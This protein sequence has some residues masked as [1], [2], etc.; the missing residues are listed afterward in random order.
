MP[1][2]LKEVDVLIAGAGPAGS[3]C[4]H[5][6]QQAGH[7]CLVVDPAEFPR[8]KICGG[9][10]TPRGW[11][12]LERLYPGLDYDY[13]PV[14]WAHLYMDGRY[15][16]RYYM[17]KEIRVVRR[18]AFD[19]LLLDEYLKAGG[20]I[21]KDRVWEVREL[22]DGRIEVTL[23]SGETVRCRYLVGA[24]GAGSRVRQYLN[25]D[26]KSRMLIFEQYNQR[27]GTD[28]ISFEL[29]GKYKNG[30][31][32]LFPNQDCDIAGYC[33]KDATRE[34]FAGVLASFGIEKTK[35][36][37]AFITTELDYPFHP[38]ILLVGDAGCWCDS[39]SYE[40]IYFALATGE[41]AAKAILENRPFQE[42]NASIL[43][44]K[45]H[46]TKAAKLLYNPVGLTVVKLISHNQH[47]TER[48]LNRYLR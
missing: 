11:E 24:D 48:I 19:K 43:E 16:G 21:L 36:L 28:E 41:N 37:G 20:A 45:L 13:L 3:A 7:D 4:A 27:S 34:K 47:L 30:Y 26:S 14:H 8:D 33:E 38:H 10:L 22:E 5:L 42:V 44:K 32:Y 15:K 9:G 23:S 6:L 2:N 18:K 17:E 31:Y 29:A 35:T 25:P 1:S 46:R 12:L 39:L 40:G